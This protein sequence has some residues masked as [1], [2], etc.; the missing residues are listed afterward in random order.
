MEL[1]RRCL[2]LP[3]QVLSCSSS[4]EA[5]TGS[6]PGFSSKRGRAVATEDKMIPPPAS[7]R[8]QR[9]P[10]R[11]IAKVAGRQPHIGAGGGAVLEEAMS[12]SGA[13]S[14]LGGCAALQAKIRPSAR[15]STPRNGRIARLVHRCSS[16]VKMGSGQRCQILRAAVWI[17]CLMDRASSISEQPGRRELNHHGCKAADMPRIRV[18][19][20]IRADR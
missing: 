3:A 15:K 14:R 10:V 6:L 5:A 18:R 2:P 8:W 17:E 9:A 12:A 4:V 1:S 7:A 19:S 16:C 11:R 13:Q 20:V